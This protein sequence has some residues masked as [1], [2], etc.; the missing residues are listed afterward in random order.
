MNPLPCTDSGFRC[1]IPKRFSIFQGLQ[2]LACVH[3]PYIFNLHVCHMHSWFCRVL[4]MQRSPA[5]CGAIGSA[6]WH[7]NIEEMGDVVTSWTCAGTIA[8]LRW[9]LC[10][11]WNVAFVCSEHKDGT[12]EMEAVGIPKWPWSITEVGL[13][14]R[15]W[16]THRQPRSRYPSFLLR[17][18]RMHGFVYQPVSS[19]MSVFLTLSWFFCG[20]E[21][22]CLYLFGSGHTLESRMS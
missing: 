12:C 21:K 2:K 6:C 4:V 8:W 16:V 19:H 3:S 1:L 10:S 14:A 7:E 5:D 18:L 13:S 15:S 22:F 17:T 9:S 11:T 20:K